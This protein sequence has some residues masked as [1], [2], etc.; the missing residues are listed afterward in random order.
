MVVLVWSD[1]SIILSQRRDI[2]RV[3]FRGYCHGKYNPYCTTGIGV[4]CPN[5]DLDVSWTER[6]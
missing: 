4:I 2:K 6:T 5:S 1:S 3:L